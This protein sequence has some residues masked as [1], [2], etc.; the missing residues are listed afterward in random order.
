VSTDLGALGKNKISR[1][2]CLRSTNELAQETCVQTPTWTCH[3]PFFLISAD[4]S[5]QKS[6][7]RDGQVLP[8]SVYACPLTLDTAEASS[9]SAS[10]VADG[11][12]LSIS[13][14]AAP[15][16]THGHPCSWPPSSLWRALLAAHAQPRL[17]T[18]EAPALTPCSCTFAERLCKDYTH[19]PACSQI[20]L[21]WASR[22]G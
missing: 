9:L 11:S 1:G 5:S 12:G 17:L 18:G 2:S 19:H 6:V 15:R 7:G 10:R 13:S 21:P 16:Q 8:A 20:S 22:S 14:S 4:Y 3:V